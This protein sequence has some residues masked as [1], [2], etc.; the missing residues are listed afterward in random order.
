MC[1]F[2]SKGEILKSEFSLREIPAHRHPYKKINGTCSHFPGLD[3]VRQKSPMAMLTSNTQY[4]IHTDAAKRTA[5]DVKRKKAKTDFQRLQT[6]RGRLCLS[7]SEL[8]TDFPC[9]EFC[10]RLITK[11]ADSSYCTVKLFLWSSRE[12][13]FNICVC[14]AVNLAPTLSH[15]APFLT[16]RLQEVLLFF[17]SSHL[18]PTVPPSCR[19]F[20][21]QHFLYLA[22]NENR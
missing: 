8:Q 20:S 13:P 2:L 9:I 3:L 21:S 11:T 1:Y 6:F 15:S 19:L 14:A 4:S 18:R 22:D 12:S 17:L 16:R 10:P 5:G 7:I